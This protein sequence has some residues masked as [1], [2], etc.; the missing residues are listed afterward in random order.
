VIRKRFVGLEAALGMVANKKIFD[1]K[2]IA[3]IF[4]LSFRH[5]S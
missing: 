2:T 4:F 1:A 3:G 5:S